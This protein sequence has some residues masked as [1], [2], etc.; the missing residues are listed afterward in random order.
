MRSLPAFEHSRPQQL[1]EAIDLLEADAL[2]YHGGTELLAVMRIG[3]L[4][5]RRLVDLKHVAGLGDIRLEEDRL[6][7]GA[8]ATHLQ[9]AT[10]PEVKRAEPVLAEVCDRVGNIRVRASGTLGGNLCFAEPRS[11]LAT[12][13]CALGADVEL[14]SSQGSRSLT[15]DEFILGGY[16]V[17]LEPG[18]LLT[19]VTVPRVPTRT[20]VYRKFQT[21]ER[22]TVGVAITATSGAPSAVRV[23]VGAVTD[24]PLIVEVDNLEN[25]D[26]EAIAQEVEVI[27]DLGG[28]E[29]YKRHVTATTIRRTIADLAGGAPS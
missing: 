13:L 23:V 11:D 3:L 24:R 10:S 4:Q 25:V 6:V 8:G 21:A 7:L 12:V 18:E 26:P 22:P 17:E 5:P 9:V 19:S 28:A 1:G 20:A 16:T 14:R 29:D 2:P 15:L 27:E